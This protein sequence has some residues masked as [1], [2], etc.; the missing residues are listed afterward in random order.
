[1]VIANDAQHDGESQMEPGVGGNPALAALTGRIVHP[2]LAAAIGALDDGGMPWAILRGSLDGS[3]EELDVL[4]GAEEV[5]RIPATLAPAGFLPMPAIGHGGHRF[6]R[7]YDEASDRWFTLDVVADLAFGEGRSLPLP[8]SA[9]SVLDR[10]SRDGIAPWLAPDDGFWALL[11]HDLLDRASIPDHHGERLARLV[12]DAGADGPIGRAIDGLAGRGTSGQLIE[13]VARDD[14]PAALAAGRRLERRWTRVDPA[15]TIRRRG[16]HWIARRLRKPFTALRRPGISVAILGPDGAGK[17]TLAEALRT[18]FPTPTRTIYLGLY[19]AGMDAGGPF[20]M[21][22]RMG[23]LWRGWLLGRWHRWRGRLVVYDRY[24]LDALVPG[25][26]A[27]VRPRIRHWI[28]TH[29][30]PLPDLI[31]VLDAPADVMLERKGEGDISTLDAQRARYREI[32]RG[33]AEAQV[34]D[35]ARGA[36]LVRRDVTARTWRRLAQGY[37]GG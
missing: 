24:A 12:G 31:L 4:V 6:F 28:L 30:I 21:V 15:G 27:R 18:G 25:R 14:R 3:D 20:G 37:R 16:R 22:R 13:L 8:V 34:V 9:A 32:A 11:L 36:D 1:M 19:G 5:G 33:L 17:S 35:A 7:A 23:R 26:A 10:R 29:A 2:A